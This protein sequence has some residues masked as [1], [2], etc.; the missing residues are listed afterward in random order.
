[1]MQTPERRE[2][3][4]VRSDALI[5][6]KTAQQTLGQLPLEERQIVVMRI[7]GEL[8]FTQ[9]AGIMQLS[10]STVHGRYTAALEQMRQRLEQPCR[11]KP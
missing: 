9:I 7:W 5:D 4:E 3:F 2:W 6:A 11:N 1:M 10:V 8:G